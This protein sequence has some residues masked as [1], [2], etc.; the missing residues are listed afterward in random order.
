MDRAGN[1]YIADR[2]NVRVRRV[3]AASSVITTVAGTGESGSSGDGGP[4]TEAVIA[5]PAGVVVDEA[6][7]LFIA[8]WENHRVRRVDAATDVI[9][10]VAGTGASGFEF[11]GFDGDGGPATAAQLYAPTDVALDGA[12]NLFIADT[13]N[14]RV[15]RV[16]AATGIIT[17]VA[18]TGEAGFGGDG[19]PATDARVARPGGV[20]VD[21]AGNL[22]IAMS[23]RRIRRVEGVAVPVGCQ[24]PVRL[25]LPDRRGAATLQP[26]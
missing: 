17:T 8:D 4:A 10:T 3:D 12:G 25:G 13:H 2:N 26:A 16:D 18:G 11:G 24:N 5:T 21:G 1:L 6:G 9:T 19:G 20:A 15:R 22:F 23:F 14:H 7:N